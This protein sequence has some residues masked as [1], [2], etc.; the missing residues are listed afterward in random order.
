MACDGRGEDAGRDIIGLAGLERRFGL[1]LRPMGASTSRAMLAACLILTASS[2][3]AGSSD[4]VPQDAKPYSQIM[5]WSRGQFVT[6]LD[7]KVIGKWAPS[8]VGPCVNDLPAT[9]VDRAAVTQLRTVGKCPN[10]EDIVVVSRIP[11]P[12]PLVVGGC[13]FD[14]V[15]I[16]GIIPGVF[17][18]TTRMLVANPEALAAA[19]GTLP[20]LRRVFATKEAGGVVALLCARLDRSS[21]GRE[22]TGAR[23]V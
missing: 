13:E 4:N 22:D 3:I 6:E 12:P 1:Y 15:T 7:G 18:E 16:D 5:G 9:Y 14:Y 8:V 23:R 10:G 17:Q 20:G 21:K 11:R 19:R 2:A